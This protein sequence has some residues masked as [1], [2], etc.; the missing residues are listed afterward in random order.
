MLKINKN[1]ITVGQ[2]IVTTKI[3]YKESGWGLT[4]DP[5][6]YP[7]GRNKYPTKEEYLN[8]L[9][10]LPVG[11]VFTIK[12][13][14]ATHVDIIVDDS[15]VEYGLYWSNLKTYTDLG[16]FPNLGAQKVEY[17][18]YLNGEDFKKKKFKDL[19]KIKASL[20]SMM[21]YSSKFEKVAKQYLD[22][23][24]ENQEGMYYVY[25]SGT[26]YNRSDF[27]Q[28]EVFEIISNKKGKKVDFD[29][30]GYYDEMIKFLSVSAQ[31]GPAARD[32]FKKALLKEDFK[33]I[34]VAVPKD[35]DNHDSYDY[36]YLKEDETIKDYVKQAKLRGVI[37]SSK[38][39]K[40]AIAFTS[41]S[42]AMKLT[43]LLLKDSFYVL[44]MNGEELVEKSEQFIV[45]QSR[46]EKLDNILKSII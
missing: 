6:Y 16:D 24:P 41:N 11:T 7:G 15:G 31:F 22:R 43:T 8:S 21:G 36:Q 25:E 26:T 14:S 2:K 1:Q 42:D 13:A 37:K 19:G 38:M 44:N 40:T 30:V 20:M 5:Y 9:E 29:F 28:L 35:Y 4:P 45:Q 39:G 3:L 33:T 10:T 32:C 12:H 17:K 18:M 34:V 46:K 23:C 27:K